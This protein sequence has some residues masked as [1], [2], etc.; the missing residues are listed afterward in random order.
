MERAKPQRAHMLQAVGCAR[1]LKVKR[2][3]DSSPYPPPARCQRAAGSSRRSIFRIPQVPVAVHRRSSPTLA[4]SRAVLHR[5]VI[6]RAGRAPPPHPRQGRSIRFVLTGSAEGRCRAQLAAEASPSRPRKRRRTA[7]ACSD[8]KPPGLPQTGD[9]LLRG[10]RRLH[11]RLHRVLQ[12]LRQV[13]HHLLLVVRSS[14]DTPF[15]P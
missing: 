13:V 6:R 2:R 11:R 7:S 3:P 14:L 1:Q 15:S 9:P 10:P 4:L 12:L 5:P 8:L